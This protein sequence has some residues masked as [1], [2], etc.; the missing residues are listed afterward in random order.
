VAITTE[1]IK[2]GLKV[3]TVDRSVAVVFQASWD[4]NDDEDEFI[5]AYDRVAVYMPRTMTRQQL[6]DYLNKNDFKIVGK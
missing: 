1:E 3:Q 5:L 4:R 6:A 2:R